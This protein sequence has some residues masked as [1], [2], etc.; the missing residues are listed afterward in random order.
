M[1]RPMHGR[2]PNRR[3]AADAGFSILEL[4]VAVGMFLMVSAVSFTLFSRHQTLLAKE[5]AVSGLDLGLRGA[6][7]QI[8]NDLVNGG[9]GMIMGPNLPNAPV[10]AAISNNTGT[11]CQN[12]STFTYASSCFDTMWVIVPDPTYQL[13]HATAV[14]NTST[15]SSI[16]VA[17]VAANTPTNVSMPS[18]TQ[19]LFIKALTSGTVFTTAVLSSATTFN[20]TNAVT[21]SYHSTQS[22]GTNSST[23]NDPESITVGVDAAEAAEYFTS[24]F[25]TNSWIVALA[26]IK[27]YVDTSTASDWRHGSVLMRQKGSATASKV[28]EQVIGFKVGATCVGTTLDPHVNCSD[29]TVYHYSNAASTDYNGD[30]TAIRSIRATVLARTPPNPTLG[31][32][33][34]FDGG[35]YQVVGSSVVVNPRNENQF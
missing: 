32:V 6:L 7:A 21:M 4:G 1:I 5:Q 22:G 19:I 27:Y 28:L 33:N 29:T 9:A 20:G 12:T 23:S 14:F 15:N 2:R 8:Q 24:S 13:M 16:S 3:R 18:G 10:G 30:F 11:S 31:F 35:P 34:P 17:P 25:D 26:P